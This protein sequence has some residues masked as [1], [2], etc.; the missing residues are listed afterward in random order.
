MQAEKP[1][2]TSE[3]LKNTVRGY[4]FIQ[5][6][7]MDDDE[8]LP[9]RESM[10]EAWSG[11]FLDAIRAVLGCKSRTSKYGSFVSVLSL[12]FVESIGEHPSISKDLA[13]RYGYVVVIGG[14][15]LLGVQLY[16]VERNALSLNA[17]L[18]SFENILQLKLT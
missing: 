3:Q 16:F 1:S 18:G 12:P 9:L 17:A 8:M 5:K 13:S 15:G 14:D 4:C 2:A 6:R 10:A 11:L 7:W